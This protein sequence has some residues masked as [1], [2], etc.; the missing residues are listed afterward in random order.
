MSNSPQIKFFILMRRITFDGNA[1][2]KL[3]YVA[4]RMVVTV[5]FTLPQKN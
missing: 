1:M 3:V 4:F 2:H 5:L